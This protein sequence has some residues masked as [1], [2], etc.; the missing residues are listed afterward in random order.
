MDLV[1]KL[2]KRA[3]ELDPMAAVQDSNGY[4]RK[5]YNLQ[6]AED[7]YLLEQA[8]KRIRELEVVNV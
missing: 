7:R 1:E 3:R 8:A 6:V 2:E 4:W 5:G